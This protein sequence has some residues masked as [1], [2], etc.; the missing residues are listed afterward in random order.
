MA[1]IFRGLGR[2]TCG[3]VGLD[4]QWNH[5][6]LVPVV[7]WKLEPRISGFQTEAARDRDSWRPR[8][9]T[10]MLHEQPTK[11]IVAQIAT[12]FPRKKTYVHSALTS[13]VAALSHQRSTSRC[14]PNTAGNW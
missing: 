13:Q 10:C 4:P 14:S 5:G 3:A 7:S 1:P 9:K 12:T 11:A 2:R 6:A 8:R